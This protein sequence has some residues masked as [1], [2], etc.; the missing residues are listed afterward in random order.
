MSKPGTPTAAE[1]DEGPLDTT[2]NDINDQ[3][4][5][6]SLVVNILYRRFSLDNIST[7][8]YWT[9]AFGRVCLWHFIDGRP[10]VWRLIHA[11]LRQ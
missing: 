11:H 9:S 10:Y 8:H 5:H 1:Q 3:N 2:F 6:V 7:Y 4:I